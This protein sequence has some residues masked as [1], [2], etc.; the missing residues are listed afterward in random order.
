M[1][2]LLQ[3]SVF[4]LEA[5]NPASE[6]QPVETSPF[7]V[8]GNVEDGSG[9]GVKAVYYTTD[10]SNPISSSSKI[11]YTEAIRIEEGDSCI[12]AVCLDLNGKY[13]KVVTAKYT[14]KYTKPDKPV[15]S[16]ENGSFTT[17]TFITVTVPENC[18]VY[19]TWD[20]TVPNESSSLYSEPIRVIEGNNILSLVSIDDHGMISDVLECNYKY[21]P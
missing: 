12:K 7:T 9:S 1:W 18:N 10:G 17:E 19:Y 15:V 3:N 4:Q 14:V 11:E 20:G 21:L 2:F 13:S 8:K 6:N 5:T 16:I